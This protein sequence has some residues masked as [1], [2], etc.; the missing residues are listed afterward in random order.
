MYGNLEVKT[1]MSKDHVTVGEIEDYL[2]N[3]IANILSQPKENIDTTSPLIN[4]GFD[5]LHIQQFIANVEDGFQITIDSDLIINFEN[6]KELADYL[7]ECVNEQ[8]AKPDFSTLNGFLDK[9]HKSIEKTNGNYTEFKEYPPYLQL[10][11]MQAKLDSTIF[12]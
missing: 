3:N 6:I 11:N 9:K 4:F 12:F 8:Q 7:L 5:S 2:Q 1:M 10:K